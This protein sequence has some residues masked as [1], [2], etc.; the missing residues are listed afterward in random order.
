M[1]QMIK[2]TFST[3]RS[4]FGAGSSTDDAWIDSDALLTPREARLKKAARILQWTA[5]G[6]AAL[7]V[8]I[9]LIVATGAGA[10]LPG[11]LVGGFTG[12]AATAIPVLLLGIAVV[13]RLRR[14]A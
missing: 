10:S 13:P 7:A 4:I 9:L 3:V 11:L 14:P 1:T 2:N 12:S 5:A 6:N 8:P